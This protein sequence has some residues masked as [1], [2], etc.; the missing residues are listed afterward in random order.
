MVNSLNDPNI[1]L[2]A[3]FHRSPLFF[4]DKSFFFKLR[5]IFLGHWSPVVAYLENEDLVLVLDVDQEY[6]AYLVPLERL[7]E[8]TN[9]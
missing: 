9:T 7:Y 3:N 2:L 6:G 4:S 5:K 1:R 8:A